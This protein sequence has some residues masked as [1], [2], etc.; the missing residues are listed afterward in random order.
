MGHYLRGTW[1]GPRRDFEGA[2][3]LRGESMA[4]EKEYFSQLEAEAVE[5]AIFCGSGKHEMK[6]SGSGSRSSKRILEAE[7]IKNSP[8]PHHW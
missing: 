3:R 2:G 5:A 8:L 7:A 1:E 6:G 4:K